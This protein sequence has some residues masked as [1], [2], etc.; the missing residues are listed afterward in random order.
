M[1]LLS[2]I[3]CPSTVAFMMDLQS[4]RHGHNDTRADAD[5]AS[6][7][8]PLERATGDGGSNLL[9]QAAGPRPRPHKCPQAG[10]ARL[11]KA[12]D[13]AEGG[14]G[15]RIVR[16]VELGTLALSARYLGARTTEM[17]TD[18]DVALVSVDHLV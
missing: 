18:A 15:G 16:P 3:R 9:V 5:D 10:D 4:R 2:A 7:S 17:S 13:P 14:C 6:A 11:S 8:A 1:S 12:A